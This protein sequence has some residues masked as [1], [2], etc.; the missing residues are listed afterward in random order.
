MRAEG[1]NAAQL[2]MSFQDERGAFES[3]LD[4]YY[5]T[6]PN[7]VSAIRQ[8]LERTADAHPEWS[9]WQLKEQVY[10]AVSTRCPVVV[11]RHFPFYCELGVGKPRTNLGEGALAVF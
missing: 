5:A 2:P 7:D 11:F 3:A 10:E 9:S 8:D 6:C 4:V 1:H